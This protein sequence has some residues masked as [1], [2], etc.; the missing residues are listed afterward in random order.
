MTDKTAKK[1]VK[2]GDNMAVVP[3]AKSD[4]MA[5]KSPGHV[6]TPDADSHQLKAGRVMQSSSLAW[7]RGHR[8]PG[9]S[10]RGCGAQLMAHNGPLGYRDSGGTGYPIGLYTHPG[11]LLYGYL[12]AE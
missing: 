4:K 9:P 3:R 10:I 8:G 5:Q 2:N 7:H 11:T 1:P 6:T 12:L